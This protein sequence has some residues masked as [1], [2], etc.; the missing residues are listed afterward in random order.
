MVV[1]AVTMLA[2]NKFDELKLRWSTFVDSPAVK[3]DHKSA[4]TESI[5][6]GGKLPS[7]FAH[8]MDGL[9]EISPFLLSS[10]NIVDSTL[11]LIR[12]TILMKLTV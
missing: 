6:L 7:R 9:R 5:T 2:D 12:S 10:S 3:W 8:M 1:F 11:E 4:G